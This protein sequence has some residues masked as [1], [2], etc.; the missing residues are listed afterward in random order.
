[1]VDGAHD[2]LKENAS[3]RSIPPCFRSRS[4]PVCADCPARLCHL[5][6]Q[7][8]L[9]GDWARY[10]RN[11]A[12]ANGMGGRRRFRLK[13][14]LR[15]DRSTRGGAEGARTWRNAIVAGP[16]ERRR[17]NA[18]AAM[19]AAHQPRPTSR[20]VG[21]GAFGRQPL[22]PSTSGTSPRYLCRACADRRT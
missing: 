16:D 7:D 9:R 20:I 3:H 21:T 12:R 17:A 11:P 14:E 10:R 2:P 15:F 13:W 5:S 18:A 22:V 19:A 4:R 6:S 8:T 1:M